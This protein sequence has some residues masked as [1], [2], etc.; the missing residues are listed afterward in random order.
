[1]ISFCWRSM[2]EGIPRWLN[3]NYDNSVIEENSYSNFLFVGC[4]H[5]FFEFSPC[6]IRPIWQMVE[7]FVFLSLL[8]RKKRWFD[9]STEWIELENAP[10]I[11]IFRAVEIV[12]VAFSLPRKD[13]TEGQRSKAQL[14]SVSF[15][16]LVIGSIL[17]ERRFFVDDRTSLLLDSPS[18]REHE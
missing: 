7:G 15:C 12:M 4:W 5:N 8:Q 11:L 1:M 10:K 3:V 16:V 14:F 9:R 6:G 17:S 2:P 18:T 13:R